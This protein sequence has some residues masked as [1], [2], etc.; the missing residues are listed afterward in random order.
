M[1]NRTGDW[2]DL[3]RVVSLNRRVRE[4]HLPQIIWIF[5]HQDGVQGLLEETVQ[6]R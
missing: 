5:C 6:I 4:E 1:V 3:I 2:K